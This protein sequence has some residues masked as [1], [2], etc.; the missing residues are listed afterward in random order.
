MALTVGTLAWVKP[1]G[2][3]WRMRKAGLSRRHMF[4]SQLIIVYKRMTKA[5]RSVDRKKN[6]F[7]CF[8]SRRAPKLHALRIR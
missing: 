6:V 1:R 4:T 5:V 8:G 2:T 3:V 7:A